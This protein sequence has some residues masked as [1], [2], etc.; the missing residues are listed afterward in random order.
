MSGRGFHPLSSTHWFFIRRERCLGLLLVKTSFPFFPNGSS[1]FSPCIFYLVDFLLFSLQVEKS[2]KPFLLKDSPVIETDFLSVVGNL[3]SFCFFQ[4][5]QADVQLSL[6]H[7][8]SALFFLLEC[9]LLDPHTPS[10]LTHSRFYD[11]VFSNKYLSPS[12]KLGSSLPQTRR[13]RC[14]PV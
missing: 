7:E 14:L 5:R 10:C 9:L 1:P 3:I 13:Y 8:E 6:R 4:L 11:M 12:Y 2:Q